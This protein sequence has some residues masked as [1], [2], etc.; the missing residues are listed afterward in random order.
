MPPKNAIELKQGSD[1][2]D[3]TTGKNVGKVEYD[4]NT[5]Q[6][7]SKGA[8]TS[9][10]M[11]T[12]NTS[13]TSNLL[14][15]QP[16][17]TIPPLTPK[18]TT[19]NLALSNNS[20]VAGIQA[21]S[22]APDPVVPQ[23]SEEKN[24]LKSYLD[25]IMGSISKQADTVEDINKDAKLVEKKATA[26]RIS[27][28]LTQ[29]DKDYR[30][31]VNEI[32]KNTQ[33]KFGGA[34]QQDIN[35]ATDRYQNNRAN[36]S[37]AYNTALGDYQAAQDTVNLKVGALKD[38]NAQAIQAYNLMADSI[39]NDLTESEQV[40]L[41]YQKQL[42]LNSAKT[43]EDAYATYLNLAVQN[44]APSSVLAAIDAAARAEEATAATI[45]AAAGQ[46]GIDRGLQAGIAAKNRS[47][48]SGGGGTS[49]GTNDSD[50]FTSTQL[51][52]GAANA[53]LPLETF[54]SLNP[55]TQNVFINNTSFASAFTSDLKDYQSGDKNYEE[56]ISEI[57]DTSSFTDETKNDL[58][59]IIDQ[60]EVQEEESSGWW[61]KI[62]GFLG[63]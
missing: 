51:N 4:V 41:Q 1:F 11:P 44:N 60:V 35:D 10:K 47:N 42:K 30:D 16:A 12:V 8:S 55:N 5:G 34:V 14:K 33:G 9:L 25:Q 50:Y 49:E 6:R 63:F 22:S 7:L 3:S 59:G 43:R 20:T 61:S 29:M 15:P 32:R 45:A 26:V 38:Q 58:I 31:E 2:Y 52:K 23:E 27:N 40:E 37:I 17:V 39:Q 13:I 56:L 57:N 28:E 19:D 24:I 48:Q 53:G 36:V 18:R 21:T 46:Y 62:K 54:N